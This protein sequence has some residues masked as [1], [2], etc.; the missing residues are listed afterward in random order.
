[1]ELG[2]R[3]T[4]KLLNTCR[5]IKK[6]I[7]Q[8]TRK[9]ET[10][11]LLNYWT[12]SIYDKKVERKVQ[13]RYEFLYGKVLYPAMLFAILSWL[14]NSYLYF[15]GV[16]PIYMVYMGALTFVNQL[17]MHVLY[18]KL[19]RHAG[20]VTTSYLFI[21]GLGMSLFLNNMLGSVS[22]QTRSEV[23]LQYREL[24]SLHFI[25][26][27]GVQMNDWRWT[28]I[29]HIPQFLF[30]YCWQARGICSI[31]GDSEQ[32]CKNFITLQLN[33]GLQV[34]IGILISH[35]VQQY[36]RSI[37]TIKAEIIDRQQTQLQHFFG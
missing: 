20:K 33:R 35:Y 13:E 3:A 6:R 30:F 24:Y 19:R 5:R 32:V 8:L 34:A 17:L 28:G 29:M 27:N 18:A 1:M 37:L 15:K 12:L 21:H 14:N 31:N 23:K 2:S 36:E 7:G 16:G 10:H 26:M 11:Y 9:K 22:N 4:F 25:L